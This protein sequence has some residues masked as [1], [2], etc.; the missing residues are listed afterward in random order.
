MMLVLELS[1]PRLQQRSRLQLSRLSATY[2]F[3]PV[4]VDTGVRAIE[5]EAVQFLLKLGGRI[6]AVTG[7]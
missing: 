2:C 5:E 1:L 4:T 6:A 3:T 7:E